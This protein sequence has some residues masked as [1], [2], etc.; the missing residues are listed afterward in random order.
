MTLKRINA[1]QFSLEGI[2]VPRTGEQWKKDV[3]D[4]NG[5]VVTS[6]LSLSIVRSAVDLNSPNFVFQGA[7]LARNANVE[8]G[9]TVK[10][11][12]TVAIIRMG[13]NQPGRVTSVTL[14]AR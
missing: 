1:V 5:N 8:V 6:N 12:A 9:M 13:G 3:L 14:T 11:D 2:E 10:C 7:G 4:A